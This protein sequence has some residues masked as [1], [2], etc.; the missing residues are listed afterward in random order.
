MKLDRLF[1]AIEV[2]WPA[3]EKSV[4]PL[5]TLRRGAGGGKRVSAATANGPMDQSD[6]LRAEA[7]MAEFGQ[8]PLFMLRPDQD[9]LDHMLAN[10]GYTLLD[11]TNVYCIAVDRLT[12]IPVPRVTTFCVW[13]P[14]AIM[15]EIWA[16]GGI[17]P[18]RLAVMA[19][20]GRKT[21][22]LARWSEKPAGAA[23]VALHE[24]ICMVH[25][26]EVLP[27]HRRQGVAQWIMRA[28][29][30]WAREQGATQLAVLC[31]QA[32]APANNLYSSLGFERVGHYHYRHK[33]G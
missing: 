25:A 11:P 5:W 10:Q 2:T 15:K 4:S 31:T 23:F 22:I 12:D 32:N 29:A 26:V 14:L 30:F 18:E 16:K 3:A 28:A 13:E 17:G 8:A 1:E 24:D 19:R 6:L 7:A 21:G 9:A 20:A 33:A 27:P